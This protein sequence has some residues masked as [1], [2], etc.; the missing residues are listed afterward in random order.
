MPAEQG[1][2][3]RRLVLCPD[4]F[5]VNRQLTLI[6]NRDKHYAAYYFS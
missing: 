3:K 5:S 4:P 6:L 1:P 2:I